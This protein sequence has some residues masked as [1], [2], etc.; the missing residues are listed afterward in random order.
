MGHE[1][2]Q[3]NDACCICVWVRV[4]VAGLG[5]LLAAVEGGKSVCVR[6]E[7]GGRRRGGRHI[8]CHREEGRIR[9]E[10]MRGGNL[11]RTQPD[12]QDTS[13]NLRTSDALSS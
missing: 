8:L 13:P 1:R 9:A 12:R 10:S 7:G 6:G 11:S 5:L 3:L 2:G 4:L